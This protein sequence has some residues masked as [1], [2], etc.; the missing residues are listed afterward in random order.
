MVTNGG[1]SV[2]APVGEWLALGGYSPE[3]TDYTG[4]ADCP[5]RYFYAYQLLLD[6]RP[7]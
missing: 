3:D 6:L 2:V 4:G 1:G 5:G 7:D